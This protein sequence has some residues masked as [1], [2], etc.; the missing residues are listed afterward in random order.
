MNSLW[1]LHTVYPDHEVRTAEIE[2]L[3]WASLHQEQFIA[4]TERDTAAKHLNDTKADTNKPQGLYTKKF[5]C[6]LPVL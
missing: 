2:I 6:S 5:L 1:M 3:L 4:F